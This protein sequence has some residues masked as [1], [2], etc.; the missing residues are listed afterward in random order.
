MTN[1]SNFFHLAQI[2][3]VAKSASEGVAG[4]T[5]GVSNFISGITDSMAPMLGEKLPKIIGALVILVCL[6]YTSPSPRDQR[7]SRMPSSA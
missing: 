6:L 2:D 4:A 3:G 5:K 7:G 1:L